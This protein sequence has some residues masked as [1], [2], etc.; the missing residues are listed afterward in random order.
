MSSDGRKCL[1]YLLYG[2]GF[3][4]R[5]EIKFSIVSALRESGDKPIDIIVYTDEPDS[6]YGW[7]V[8]VVELKPE[9]LLAWTGEHGYQHRRKAI[10]IQDSLRRAEQVIFIDTDTFFIASPHA[11]FERLARAD[12][13]VDE[14]EG[15]WG[16][17]SDQVIYRATAA[18][19]REQLGIGDDMLLINSGVLGFSKCG[20]D[21]MAE[22]ISLIDSLYPLAPD[23]HVIEQFAVGCAAR[24]LARPAQSNGILCHYFGEK[25]FWRAM[26]AEFFSQYCE[27]YSEALIEA[28]C[29]FPKKRIKPIWWRRLHL[30]LLSL[31]LCKPQRK[32]LRAAFFSI[33]LPS[34]AYSKAC[35]FVYAKDYQRLS[36][37]E[38]ER[39]GVDGVRRFTARQNRKLHDVLKYA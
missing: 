26:L 24:K 36:G 27:L 23:V 35:S 8:K 31:G 38:L 29:S 3:S 1:V 6:F 22:A 18:R 30:R 15:V 9:T 2:G 20:E 28:S 16:G 11:L 7:P 32:V 4:Y 14:V 12:W 10:A 39:D 33:Y 21:I 19:L 37:S 5:Q 34:D 17:W 25:A 13:I